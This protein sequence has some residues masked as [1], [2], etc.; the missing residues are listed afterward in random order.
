MTAWTWL[1]HSTSGLMLRIV[2]GPAIFALLAISDLRR[3]GRHATRWREYTFLLLCVLAAM[4]YGVINDLITSTL[5]WEYFY[6]G[7]DLASELGPQ[8]PPDPLKLHLAAA[9]VG[10]K[11]TWSAGLLIGVA[12]LLANNPSK[13]LPRLQN[14]TLFTQLPLL[15]LITAALAALGAVAGHFAL[16]ARWNDDFAQM[17]HRNEMRHR[18]FMTVYGIHLGGYL[19]GVIGTVIAAGRIRSQRRNK[20]ELLPVEA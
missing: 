2:I 20:I 16:P 18:R 12:L 8:T 13:R 4:L 11:A 14:R 7:K 6:Y 3:H 19:G 5:S 10:I 17:L 9:L 15:L 1:I